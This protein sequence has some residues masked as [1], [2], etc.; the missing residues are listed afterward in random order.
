MDARSQAA[1]IT[2]LKRDYPPLRG[3]PSEIEYVSE[4]Y[5]LVWFHRPG[6]LC[7]FDKKWNFK[8][9][10]DLHADTP[11]GTAAR[12]KGMYHLSDDVLYKSF[13]EGK[14]AWLLG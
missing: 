2:A 14:V 1:R 10:I 13:L 12:L 11:P 6:V 8:D 4:K 7:G 5:P 3:T 9:D